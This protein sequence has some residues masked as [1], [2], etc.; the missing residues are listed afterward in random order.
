MGGSYSKNIKTMHVIALNY[1][2]RHICYQRPHQ[3]KDIRH[4]HKGCH[5]ICLLCQSCTKCIQYIYICGI[6][7]YPYC[8]YHFQEHLKIRGGIY[9][10]R[11]HFPDLKNLKTKEVHQ[12]ILHTW[13]KNLTFRGH[14][15]VYVMKCIGRLLS[16]SDF[17][18]S[19]GNDVI[20]IMNIVI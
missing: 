1:L 20:L 4:C 7:K 19:L 6:C 2:S 18:E 17:I 15:S 14:C 9:C 11:G 16:I 3:M 13:A 5:P 12:M 10:L 8:L